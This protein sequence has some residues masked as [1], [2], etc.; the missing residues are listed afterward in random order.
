MSK[1]LRLAFPVI[2]SLILFFPA[3]SQ[4][5]GPT[6][7]ECALAGIKSPA[8]LNRYLSRLRKA[9]KNNDKNAVAKLIDYPINIRTNDGKDELP[10]ENAAEFVKKY[11]TIITQAVRKAVLDKPFF[12][13]QGVMLSNEHAMLI[14]N[15]DG[16]IYIMSLD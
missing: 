6:K 13:R 12:N 4:A 7:E 11:D 5:S 9:I 15:S 2:V 16:L 1:Y 14:L 3:W 8:Q 10:I